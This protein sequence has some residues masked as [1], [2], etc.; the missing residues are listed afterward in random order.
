MLVPSPRA[1]E[2]VRENLHEEKNS[3]SCRAE[4]LKAM[5]VA[6]APG[7]D[8]ENTTQNFLRSVSGALEAIS[9]NTDTKSFQLFSWIRRLVTRASTDAVYGAKQNPFQDPAVEA[10]FW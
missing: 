1:M 9:S 8:L 5:H 2:I 6:L 7:K 10:G 4:I 3:F